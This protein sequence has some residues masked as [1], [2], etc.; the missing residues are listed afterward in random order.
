M[1]SSEVMC[2]GEF[3]KRKPEV[4]IWGVTQLASRPI[5]VDHGLIGHVLFSMLDSN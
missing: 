5:R 2:Q 4:P 3:P 1:A